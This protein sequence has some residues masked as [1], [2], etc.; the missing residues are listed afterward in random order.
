M[1]FNLFENKKQRG[2][3]LVEILVVIAIIGILSS[4]AFV[5][6]SSARE[7]SRM[8]NAK[9]F[10]ANHVG[11]L[12]NYLVAEWKFDDPTS[13]YLD[14]SGNGHNGSCS[15]C[16]TVATGEGFNNKDAM[17]FDGVNDQ[18]NLGIGSD[19]F[20]IETFTVCS[21]I[22]FSELGSGMTHSGVFS[23]TY[24]MSLFVDGN[25]NLTSYLD[26]NG[27]YPF[28]V[29]SNTNVRDDKYHFICLRSDSL[30]RNMY[31]DG[32]LKSST[33]SAWPGT[34]RYPTNGVVIGLEIN[35]PSIS[36][37]KGLID[38]VRVYS[39]VLSTAQIQKLYAEE[40]AQK[41]LAEAK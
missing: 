32:N 38:D 12:R 25:G 13:R 16:P 14:S 1:I 4:V 5:A 10:E 8:S 26:E 17:R 29:N 20:P 2:Y 37:F 35:N 7:K 9:M 36:R 23:M 11:V 15:N 6:F 41:K 24:V 22:K 19:Y 33:P 40:S 34:T 3:T 39:S 28:S 21:W 30:K 27:L 18:I 31:V